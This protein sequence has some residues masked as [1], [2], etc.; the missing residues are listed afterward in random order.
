MAL[1]SEPTALAATPD[2]P[3]TRRAPCQA[4]A[5]HKVELILEAATRLLDAGDLSILATNAVAER[6]GVSIGTLYP[7]FKDKQAILDALALRELDG[8]EG[9]RL[10]FAQRGAA[11]GA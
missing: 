10:R 11:A 8:R 7:Y 6:A 1:F 3:P 4:R 2:G 5:L 9:L